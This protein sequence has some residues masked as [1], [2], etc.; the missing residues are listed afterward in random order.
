LEHA[1][2][3]IARSHR[4]VKRIMGDGSAVSHVNFLILLDVNEHLCYVVSIIRWNEE[5]DVPIYEYQC[6]KC[7]KAFQSLIM[8]PGEEEALTCPTCGGCTLSRLISRVVYH[9]PEQARLDSFD[10]KAKHGDSFYRDSRNIGLHAEKR[11]RELGVDLGSGFKERLEKLR[12]D[13]GS[14][15]KDE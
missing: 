1:S 3:L 9:A 13:P 7:G 8:K 4:P 5:E 14:V 6:G 15:L 12:T 11:A 2:Y 10:P